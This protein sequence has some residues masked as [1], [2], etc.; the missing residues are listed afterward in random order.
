MATATQAKP[1][2]APVR[3]FSRAPGWFLVYG[4]V[5]AAI[6]EEMVGS[7][8]SFGQKTLLGDTHANQDQFAWLDMAFTATQFFSFYLTPWILQRVAIQT[9]LRL[10]TGALAAL[11]GLAMLT[12]NLDLLIVLRVLQGF[13]GGSL[14][15]A[16]QGILFQAFPRARQPVLQGLFTFGAV[17]TPATVIPGIQGWLADSYN[18]IWL[19]G[20]ALLF[21][22]AGLLLMFNADSHG[23]ATEKRVPFDWIGAPLYLT[24]LYCMVYFLSRGERWNWFTAPRI[25]WTLV[26]F[27]TALAL[28]IV[29]Q[30]Y[31]PQDA[32]VFKSGIFLTEG[33]PFGAS[34]AFIAGIALFGSA[35][36]IPTYTTDVLHF[37]PTDAGLLLVP[38]GIMFVCSLSASVYVLQK[39]DPNPALTVPFGLGCFMTGMWLLAHSSAASGSAD[40]TAPLLFR[41]AA[42]GFLFISLTLIAL[43]DMRSSLVTTG[44]ALFDTDRQFGGLIGTAGLTTYI[45]HRAALSQNIF[46]SHI[47]MTSG[48]V[49]DW[50][51]TAG[52]ALGARGLDA[53]SAG[54]A[55]AGSL[56][57]RLE[58]QAMA[59]GYNSAFLVLF[60]LFLVAIPIAACLEIIYPRWRKKRLAELG[61]EA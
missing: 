14:L 5:L 35:A 39:Y 41:G 46:A 15:I 27:L 50:L 36:I 19:F 16:G 7:L 28:F 60:E 37:Q 21:L 51:S 31:L 45:H 1:V 32:R 59:I 8:T 34:F 24:A 12:S 4:I 57:Q 56:S 48:R 11:C 25:A 58:T 3:A 61:K 29:R 40:L 26:G 23:I 20:T 38:G 47:T 2:H 10:S 33:F 42:L 54:H 53:S 22:A 17:L 52:T 9:Y 13:A 6:G 49:S 43:R 18:W 55:A 44:I 30:F